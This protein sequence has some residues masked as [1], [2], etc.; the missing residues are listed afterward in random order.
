VI[1]LGLDAASVL[2][3]YSAVLGWRLEDE[4]KEESER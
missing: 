3:I 2:V 1:V 4:R